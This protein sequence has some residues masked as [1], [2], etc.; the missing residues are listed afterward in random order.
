MIRPQ[1]RAKTCRRMEDSLFCHKVAEQTDGG[2]FLSDKTYIKKM[3]HR[4]LFEEGVW[5][6]AGF[7]RNGDGST[8]HLSGR[9]EISHREN[10]WINRGFMEI[11][12]D[13]PIRIENTCEIIPFERGSDATTWRSEDPGLGTLV[14][15][16]AVVGDS[17]L[18]AFRTEDG[19]FYGT[20]YI[21]NVD[22]DT[23][24]NRGVLLHHGRIVSS[25]SATLTRL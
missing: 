20:E 10:I 11:E 9:T 2:V 22:P 14:G 4:F 19:S 3:G 21:K 6:A 13:T 23:Y 18:S 5:L 16:Y 8:M 24:A 25:W 15:T 1:D 7:F 17:I 12:G